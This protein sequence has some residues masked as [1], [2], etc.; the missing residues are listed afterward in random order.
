MTP[1]EGIQIIRGELEAGIALPKCQQC[2][3]MGGALDAFAQ[4]LPSIA[5]EEATLLAEK[6]AAWS[7]QM[8][9][10]RY[11]CLGCEHCYPAVAENA[12]ASAFPDAVLPSALVCGF[13]TSGQDWPV[14][15]GE[16][17]VVDRT[18]PVA[19]STLANVQLA[20]D[21]AKLKLPGLAITG[22]TETENIGVEKV[23]KNLIA[24]PAIQLLLIAGVES[25]GHQSGNALI[26]L[27]QNGIDEKGRVIGATGKR[28]V[29]HNVTHGEIAAF[30]K[31]IQVVD[32]RGCE[33]PQEIGARV[34]ELTAQVAVPF[35]RHDAPESEA[36]IPLTLEANTALSGDCSDLNCA[37]RTQ[38]NAHAPTI[39]VPDTGEDV[40]L[41]RAG[42]F[43]ILPVTDRNV[44][45]VEHYGYD[46]VLLH[47][48]EGP[49]ARSLYLELVRQGWVSELNHAAYLGKELAK[50]ELSLKYGFKYMQDGA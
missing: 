26:A 37:C 35:D 34:K 12:F 28:P 15:L 40:V 31:Q 44:I 48:I 6:V 8:K 7:V 2:G 39:K 22:K 1:G 46:N 9:A 25:K 36:L 13:Q 30:R 41:D 18:A 10:V 29:L 43:V 42:Y 11:S 27:A 5:G 33:D 21:L 47:T 16:Y 49:N 17:F 23:V 45:N 24:N 3:C 50:A 4:Q 32:L 38:P 20:E 19:V 14:V